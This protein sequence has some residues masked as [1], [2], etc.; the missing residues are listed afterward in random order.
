M[1]KDII[2]SYAN[3]ANTSLVNEINNLFTSLLTFIENEKNAKKDTN[4]IKS[5]LNL[6]NDNPF[7][8]KSL[9]LEYEDD[10]YTYKIILIKN[11]VESMFKA[12]FCTNADSLNNCKI[13]ELNSNDK[14]NYNMAKLR[15]EIEHYKTIQNYGKDLL[16]D[17]LLIDLDG[18]KFSNL[19][20]KNAD[21]SADSVKNAI[22]NF[23]KKKMMKN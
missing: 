7:G 14:H 1:K 17:E 6:S 20:L 9:S 3:K 5:V 10:F 15:N 11:F 4:Y 2:S 22:L 21:F 12:H 19:F 16:T 13:K 23:I 18:N 8:L